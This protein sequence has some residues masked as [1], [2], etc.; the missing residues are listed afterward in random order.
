MFFIAFLIFI[1]LA[2]SAVNAATV[3]PVERRV[4]GCCESVTH[5]VL[6]SFFKPVKIFRCFEIHSSVED[7]RSKFR[8]I[9][10][11]KELEVAFST[12]AAAEV[13]IKQHYYTTCYECWA[14][15]SGSEL[16]GLDC[17]CWMRLCSACFLKEHNSLD[18]IYDGFLRC[19]R[20]SLKVDKAAAD[21]IASELQAPVDLGV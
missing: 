21:A 1:G 17:L 4:P 12:K 18:Q 20:C 16:Y 14:E 15:N 2:T 5:T 8:I 6:D 3:R 7:W 11:G 9:A 10:Y 19:Q 13:F